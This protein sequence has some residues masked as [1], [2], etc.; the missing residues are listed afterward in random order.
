MKIKI[1]ILLLC[2][3]MSIFPWSK[4]GVNFRYTPDYVT[5]STDETYCLINEHYPISRGGAVFG[6]ASDVTINNRSITVNHRLAGVAK[7]TN[8]G[9][10][11]RIFKIDLPSTGN[12]SLRLAIGDPNFAQT[13][14]RVC[15]GDS[16]TYL[17]SIVDADGTAAGHFLDAVG[18][19]YTN[20]NWP[21][22]NTLKLITVTKKQLWITIGSA[23][24]IG[25][26]TSL[27]TMSH[28]YLRKETDCTP[29]TLS[30]AVQIDTSCVSK[31]HTPS[32]GNSPDSI[33]FVGT[34]GTSLTSFN[35]S[36]GVFVWT[37]VDTLIAEP[38]TTRAYKNGCSNVDA[39]CSLKVV[40]GTIELDSISPKNLHR[41]DTC[42]VYGRG[43]RIFE[44][45]IHIAGQ[46][47]DAVV[48]SCTNNK[49]KFIIPSAA[50]LG[51]RDT[52][53]VDNGITADTIADS[54]YNISLFSPPTISYASNPWSIRRLRAVSDVATLSGATCDSVKATGLPAGTTCNKT[55]GTISGNATTE[56]V[57]TDATITAWG[58]DSNRVLTLP[59]TVTACT[60]Y[61]LTV[62]TTGSGTSTPTT[63]LVDSGAV[64]AIAATCPHWY[65]W[66]KWTR[67]GVAAVIADTSLATT[68]AY[69]KANATV[70]ANFTLKTAAATTTVYPATGDTGISKNLTLRWNYNVADSFYIVETDTAGTFNSALHTCD[71]LTDTVKA[72]TLTRDSTTYS[73]RVKGGNSGGT[74]AASSVATFKTAAPASN[75]GGVIVGALGTVAFAAAAWAYGA[76]RK[77]RNG[78]AFR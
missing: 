77:R 56:Q 23:V 8:D 75:A 60:T 1:G 71:T 25:D 10:N 32:V 31:T 19:D 36:T 42:S 24:K 4:I 17:D 59:I 34:W 70:T 54:A 14:H 76:Y 5:D 12:Y 27:T 67:S 37:P 50:G 46:D 18:A 2:M 57:Q 55:T 29:P 74:S 63:G 69:L 43:F 49:I 47:S 30:Y 65:S 33:G 40:Y 78:G 44:D 39:V 16:N 15:I 21:G 35:H 73:W 7:G 11:F 13:Y 64:T 22:S 41:L 52:F 38:C 62:A 72:P 3:S 28:M 66:A 45:S 20:D 9:T 53:T 6:F 51:W 58:A 26:G 48:T 61:T 68:T